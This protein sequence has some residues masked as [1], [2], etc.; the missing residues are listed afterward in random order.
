MDWVENL[1]AVIDYIEQHLRED[2][3]YEELAKLANCPSSYFQKLFL[4]MTNISLSEYIRFRRLSLAAVELQ[5]ENVKIIDISLAYG[6][7]SPTA[8]NRAFKKFH[9]FA[10]SSVKKENAVLC[11]YPPIK[12]SVS[13]QGGRALNFRIE[14]KE[15]FRILGITCPLDTCLEENFKR[16]PGMWDKALEQG[17]LTRLVSMMNGHLI[18]LLGVSIHH[19]ENWKYLI[20]INSTIEN[21]AYEEYYIPAST[22]AIFSGSGTNVS[23][24]E[25]E[26]RVIVEW[27]P[28]SG[29]QCADIPDIEVYIKADPQHAIYEYWLPIT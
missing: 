9:G 1:N 5:K 3:K 25:L 19:T 12:F 24:Q 18:G 16:I 14:N 8:F 21:D 15:A 29:Y 6:Y 4:Y 20:A 11:S 7:D 23:L 13:V 26:R 10:P 27:L 17:E 28:Y 22:W 2:L